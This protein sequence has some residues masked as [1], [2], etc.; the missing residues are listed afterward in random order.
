MCILREGIKMTEII[1][2]VVLKSSDYQ[3][4]SKILQ[5][6][7]KEHGLLGIYLRGASN[8]KSPNFA[9][10]QPISHAF[11]TIRYTEGL[12]SSFKGEM[13]NAFQNL[14]LDFTKNIYVYHLFELLMRNLQ[15]HESHP[16]LYEL[17]IKTLYILENNKEMRLLKLL[18]IYFEMQ[19]LYHLGVGPVV[20]ECV[21]C[22]ERTNIA[23]FDIPHGGFVCLNHL[24]KSQK[25]YSIS[26]LELL[27]KLQNNTFEEIVALSTDVKNEVLKDLRE[28]MTNFYLY[29]LNMTT[30]AVKYFDKS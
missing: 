12:S 9:L 4:H 19:L 6:F 8:Y 13:I 26:T 3:E 2:G 30:N 16:D 17:L 5:V 25:R 1:E 14:K 28:I 23:N 11:F 18:T 7:S 24:D 29:H 15:Q 20:S 21:V 22:G 10:A 27:Y